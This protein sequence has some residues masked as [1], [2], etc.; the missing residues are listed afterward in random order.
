MG[1]YIFYLY[2]N[3]SSWIVRNP[4]KNKNKFVKCL[5]HRN[6]KRY[7][8]T[9][10]CFVTPKKKIKTDLKIVKQIPVGKQD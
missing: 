6:F 5:P 1:L 4:L 7:I 9:H 2:F 10:M 8:L 3:F